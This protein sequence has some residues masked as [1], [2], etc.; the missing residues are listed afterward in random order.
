[1]CA[2][3]AGGGVVRVVERACGGSLRVHMRQPFHLFQGW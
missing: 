2:R 3:C 1:M